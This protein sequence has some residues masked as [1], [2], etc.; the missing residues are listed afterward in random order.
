MIKTLVYNPDDGVT[1]HEG[2]IDFQ[3]L[4][5]REDCTFWVDLDKPVDEEAFI[6]TSD[7]HFHPLVI[8]DVIVEKGPP[9]LDVFD[10]YLFMVFY[11]SYY[12]SAG[13]L[14]KK[15][16]DLFLGDNFV[17]TIHNDSFPM[18]EKIRNR[19]LR[20]ERVLSRGAVFTFHTILDYLVDEFIEIQDEVQR[21]IDRLEAVVFSGTAESSILKRI[22]ELKEDIGVLRRLA[23]TQRQILWRFSK[24]E[25]KLAKG[26]SLIYFRDVFDHMNDI[27]EH[28]ETFNDLLSNILHVYLSMA[29]EKTNT[30]MKTLTIFTA[31]LL[32]LSV[33]SG[34][35]GMNFD[36][37][38]R[39]IPGS[40]FIVLGAMATIVVTLLI[41]FK[42]KDWL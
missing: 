22:F 19:C 14:G 8:E 26:A 29:S 1:V 23:T 37:P 16:I 27:V 34:I 20:D 30:I 24:G 21:F 18:L 39:N 33:I 4:I 13:E 10:K 9:K 11:I 5:S 28:A 38:E 15:E 12:K 41:I 6:L 35:Y 25:Y 32:P 3:G 31:V 36:F 40:Y 7:F 2:I 17:V 42:R